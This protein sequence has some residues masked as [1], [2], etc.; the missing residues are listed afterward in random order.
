MQL[1][2]VWMKKGIFVI[3]MMLS[4]AFLSANETENNLTEHL[5]FLTGKEL[6]GREA[7]SEGAKKAADYIYNQFKEIG[8]DAEKNV[9]SKKYQ[10]VIGTIPSKNG[11]YIIIG[12]HY[13][14]VGS[15][16]KFFPAADDNASGTAVMIELARLLSKEELEYGIKFVAFDAEEKYLLGSKHDARNTDEKNCVLV[17]SIDMVGHLKD[18]GRLIYA[19]SGTLKNGEELI[20]MSEV[21]GVGLRILSAW[22]YAGAATDT[23]SYNEKKIPSLNIYTG[24]ETS[25]FHTENDTFESI[26]IEG[27]ARIT[28]QIYLFIRNVQGKIESSSVSLYGDSKVRMGLCNTGTTGIDF[29]AMLPLYSFVSGN[30]FLK[31]QPGAGYGLKHNGETLETLDLSFGIQYVSALKLKGVESFVSAGPYYETYL[32]GCKSLVKQGIGLSFSW[33]IK[34]NTGMSGWFDSFSLGFVC[35][36]GIKDFYD[37]GKYD[38]KKTKTFNAYVGFYF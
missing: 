12:A 32:E 25:Y 33:E 29:F 27:M 18:E 28:E 30:T 19:G 38:F 26:D 4:F 34:P 2:K 36:I 6:N 11:K 17:I 5:Q 14:G 7:G 13:D 24:E 10:N 23:F 37:T 20:R 3:A 35:K 16:R 21:S 8:L 1:K 31:L 22:P 9:F 15:S